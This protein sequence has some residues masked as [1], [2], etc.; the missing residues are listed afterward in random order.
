M[1]DFV[2]TSWGIECFLCEVEFGYEGWMLLPSELSDD[3]VS[4]EIT[5][6]E[7]HM[8]PTSGESTAS[9]ILSIGESSPSNQSVSVPPTCG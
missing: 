4:A 7:H 6:A 3:E 2:R 9:A 5:A 1:G 8:H